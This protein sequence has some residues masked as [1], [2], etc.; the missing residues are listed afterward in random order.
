MVTPVEIKDAQIKLPSFVKVN[1]N[2]Q[3]I[4]GTTV[5]G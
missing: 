2:F 1:K 5:N 3:F 4:L